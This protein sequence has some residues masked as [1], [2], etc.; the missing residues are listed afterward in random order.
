MSEFLSVTEKEFIEQFT[1]IRPDR[2][3]LALKDKENGECIFLDGRNCRIQPVK[4]QQC[5]D[6]P[7]LWNFPGFK[8]ECQAIAIPLGEEEYQRRIKRATGR[9]LPI[10]QEAN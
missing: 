8:K 1:R 7:N 4:P 9:M 6:F 5:R 2:Q 10:K 3:G